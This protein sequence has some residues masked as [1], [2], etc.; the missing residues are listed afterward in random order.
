MASNPFAGTDLAEPW[1]Q[2]FIAGFLAPDGDHTPPSPFAPEAQDA[3][4]KGAATGQDAVRGLAVPPTLPPDEPGVWKDIIHTAE[5]GKVLIELVRA[6][7]EDMAKVALGG[8][9]EVFI[10]VAVFGPD[11]SEPFFEEGAA[12]AI[13][14]VMNELSDNGVIS[15]NIDLFMAACDRTD[16]DRNDKDELSRQ[17]FFHG[18]V[19]LNFDQASA[20]A[21][22]H[23]HVGD[24]VVLHFQTA[25]PDE[26]E[27]I[28]LTTTAPVT[29]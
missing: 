13:R 6:G 27:V 28:E 9:L 10:S 1:Q 2:G 19:F 26:V 21:Q 12:S 17:G 8:A 11:R 14:R 4:A 3:Y 7:G 15:D 24:T 23:G 20:Q 16:H 22:A 29:P 5:A 25:S 18:S